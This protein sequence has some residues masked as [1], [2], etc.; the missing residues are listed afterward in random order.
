MSLLTMQNMQIM[1]WLILLVLFVMTELATVGL[2]T[3][4]FAAGALA[5][6]LL[7]VIQVSFPLQITVFLVTSILLLILVRSMAQK[8]INNRA[9]KT[10]VHAVV[11]QRTRITE[12]VSNLDQTG[13]ATVLGQ[14]WSVR[15]ENDT[16]ILEPGTLVQVIRVSGVKL[17]V[18]KIEEV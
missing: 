17:I 9:E 10:N 1:V 7:A 14:D 16:Q 15:T 11:G 13:R 5:A 2:V 8:H 4:W 18:E 6:L 12:R 3:I